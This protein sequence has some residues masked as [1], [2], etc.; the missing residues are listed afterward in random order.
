MPEIIFRYFPSLSEVQ[1]KKISS[2]KQLYEEWNSRINVISRKDID[3]FYIHHVLHSLSIARFINFK[4]GTRILD[5]GTGGGFPG[6]PLS[7]LFPNSEFILLD[8]IGKKIKV[9]SAVADELKLDNV[10]LI[11]KRV[12]DEPGKYDFVVSR[13]VMEFTRFVEL[14][15][16]NLRSE[17]DN[18]PANGIICLKGGDLSDELGNLRRSV[19]IRDIKDFFSEPFFETKKI[20]YIPSS[21][22]F[23]G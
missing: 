7:I 10:S 19:T 13:A 21:F 14:T 6:I 11:W 15:L 1:R 17:S 9:A 16:K 2:L 3:N 12:E 4:P 22:S 5:V 20:V 8:S 23:P 18:K